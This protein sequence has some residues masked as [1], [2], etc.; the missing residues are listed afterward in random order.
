M[1]QKESR[2]RVKKNYLDKQQELNAEMRAI[3]MDWLNDVIIEFNLQQVFYLLN[4]KYWVLLQVTIYVEYFLRCHYEAVI[5]FF[6][7]NF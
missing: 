3:L 5:M 7:L 6:F 4:I 1:R 2:H